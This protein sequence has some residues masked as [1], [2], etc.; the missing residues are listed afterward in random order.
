MSGS[1]RDAP[2]P[3]R[4]G[5]P[6]A[7]PP[8]VEPDELPPQPPSPRVKVLHVITRFAG[9]AGG[10][11]LLAAAGMDPDLY[12]TWIAAGDGGPLW[13]QARNAGVRCVR[14]PTMREEISP[15]N[16]AAVLWRLF[17]LM[18]RERFSVVHT[19]CSKAGVLGRLAARLARSPVVVHTFHAFAA[20]P[21]MSR[22]RGMLYMSLDRLVRPLAD[23]YIAV[24]PTVAREAVETRLV[25]P[26]SIV[27]VPS[28][29]EQ[30]KI[31]DGPDSSVR[32][33]LGVSADAPVVGWVGR[34]VPQK[35]PLHFVQMAALV[36]A[37]HPDTVFVMVGDAA[38]ETQ[39][40]ERE[41]RAEASR[42][43]VGIRFLGYRADAPRVASAFD[44]HVVS[45]LYEG[46]GRG[47]TEAM[48]SGRPVVATAVNGVRDL[49]APGST[50]LLAPPNDPAAL[51]ACVRWMLDHPEERR[52]MGQRGRRR[53]S[54]MF[55]Q[56]T[57]CEMLDRV[58]AGMLGLPTR[59]SQPFSYPLIVVPPGTNDHVDE[60]P[61]DRSASPRRMR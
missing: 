55:D 56:A 57:M 10:N 3:A 21:F 50:G 51:A 26:G 1:R 58:Y 16:D 49:V 7:A 38:F 54:G 2:G 35:A 46:L 11:T 17:R 33:E 29:I 6:A 23:R 37:T 60:S 30:G 14:L 32:R 25:P 42:L 8:V 61:A 13:E 47:L 22:A 52:E 24:S 48:A 43:E 40:L 15:L 4:H 18:R 59:V 5:W 36:H 53:V 45:S 44:V 27:V 41:T 28:G 9:G 31:P 20:H 19:H 12:E 34:M 39:P